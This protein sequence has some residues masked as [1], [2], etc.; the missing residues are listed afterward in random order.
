MTTPKTRRNAMWNLAEVVVSSLVL[1]VLY[2]IILARLG[3][4]ALGIW[5]LVLA[6]TSLARVADLGAAG[7]LGRYVALSQAR[8][9]PGDAALVYAET[10]LVANAAFY[11]VLGAV[12]YWPAWQGLALVTHGEVTLE[13]RRLLPYA[14]GSFTLMNVANVLT[15]ALTGFHRSYQ[16]S[17]TMML[18]LLLQAAIAAALVS[19]LGLRAIALAQVAQYTVL[20][21]VGWVLVVRAAS[22]R[23]RLALPYR[24]R[25]EALREL[26]G[27]GLRLQVLNIV[28]FPFEPVT[29]FVF[30]AIGGLPA[31]GLYEVASRGFLQ[32]R[33]L[34]VAPSQNLTPLFAS[35]HHLGGEGLNAL[36]QRATAT[37]IAAGAVTMGGLAVGAPLISYVWLGRVDRMFV[38]YSLILAA[39][40]FVNI[41]ATPGYFL[42]VG[43]GRLRWNITGAALSTASAGLLGALLGKLLGPAGIAAGAMLGIAGGGLLTWSLNCRDL[44]FRMLPAAGAWAS[45]YRAAR[46]APGAILARAGVKA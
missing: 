24:V 15:A 18:T 40:W 21:V 26:L 36:Y 41:V 34:V 30:S 6:T 23:W 25:R 20:S 37:L 11:A 12:I 45:L 7:G 38:V 10:A 35:Q 27:F 8:G 29:K 42:G 1:F 5:S 2:K 32:V 33:Q 13:A 44:G 31:L 3:V 19:R 28:A 14:I 39:G 17:I 16:K 43:T 46:R 22:G 4:S 9:E